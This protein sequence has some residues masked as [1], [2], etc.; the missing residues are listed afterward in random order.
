[1][2]NLLTYMLKYI[3]DEKCIQKKVINFLLVQKLFYKL[4]LNTIGEDLSFYWL[5]SFVGWLSPLWG[6]PK[7]Y[8]CR[9]NPVF[10]KKH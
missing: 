5:F 7:I 3:Y 1:M 4:L 9:K 10:V 2:H 8:L 6:V